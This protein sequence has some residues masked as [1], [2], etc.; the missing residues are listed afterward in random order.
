MGA[1]KSYLIG[2]NGE[3]GGRGTALLKPGQTR[4]AFT[5]YNTGSST[6]YL[7]TDNQPLDPTDGAPLSAGSVVPWDTDLSLY[8]ACPTQGEIFV[9]DNSQVPFDAG[10]IAAQILDQGLAGEI[11]AA[12]A[13][14]GAPPIDKYTQLLDSGNTGTSFTAPNLD[15]TSYQSLFIHVSNGFPTKLAPGKFNVS[16]YS[17]GAQPGFPT[18][19]LIAQDEFFIGT[20]PITDVTLPVRGAICVI[21]VAGTSG[22]CSFQV[23]GSYKAQSR[24]HYLGTGTGSSFGTIDGDGFNGVQTWAGAL[25]FGTTQVWQPDITA[26]RNRLVVRFTTVGTVTLL[27][28]T[29]ATIFGLT[30]YITES[31]TAITATSELAYD[32]LL[33]PAPAEL[34]IA[35]TAVSG[36]LTFRA[37]LVPEP[38]Y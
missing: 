15:T 20:G 26:G 9:S 22:S 5:I 37:T 30:A 25:P 24:A 19:A 10:A 6:V 4:T 18:V 34:S 11:A 33:P 28:R 3:V 14:S 21:T 7:N 12:I 27:L 13:I 31:G 1:S 2:P 36:S 16:W 38:P 29:P 32:V 8:A 35:N 17:T 23:Y